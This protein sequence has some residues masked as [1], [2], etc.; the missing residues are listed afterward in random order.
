MAV[1]K[2]KPN[3]P[4]QRHKVLRRLLMKLQLQIPE[5]EFTS[6]I[7]KRTGGRNDRGKMTIRHVGGGHN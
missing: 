6:N 3:T 1:R 2:L 4:G 5:K 7:S